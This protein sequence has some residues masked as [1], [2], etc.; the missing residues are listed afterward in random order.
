MAHR[1]AGPKILTRECLC[2]SRGIWGTRKDIDEYTPRGIH[3]VA[4]YE[5][6]FNQL[7]EGK[8]GDLRPVTESNHRRVAVPLKLQKVADFGDVPHDAFPIGN[9]GQIAVLH[10]DATPSP[11][12]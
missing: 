6:G 5:R 8:A 9:D 7:G 11:P 4:G 12:K 2:H 1:L 3:E 10:I